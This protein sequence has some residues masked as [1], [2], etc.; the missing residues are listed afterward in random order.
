[1]VVAQC[2]GVYGLKSALWLRGELEGW[3]TVLNMCVC[4]WRGGAKDGDK[5][6]R[7]RD[8]VRVYGSW[9]D[10]RQAQGVHHPG[11]GVPSTGTLSL[12]PGGQA[13][14]ALRLSLPLLAWLEPTRMETKSQ[15]HYLNSDGES[16]KE[17]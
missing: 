13:P 9:V 8:C 6:G 4:V 1:M 7:R 3:P 2:P 17:E 12:S 15:Q 11:K 5:V 14:P 10:S 16:S